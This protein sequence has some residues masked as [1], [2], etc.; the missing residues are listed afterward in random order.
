MP[1]EVPRP[2]FSL[3]TAVAAIAARAACGSVCRSASRGGEHTVGM[4]EDRYRA[5]VHAALGHQA[6]RGL[7]SVT[8][9][10]RIV[11]QQ[12]LSHARADA[13]TGRPVVASPQVRAGGCS[14]GILAEHLAGSVA[15]QRIPPPCSMLR[16]ASLAGGIL[17]EHLAGS[18]APQRIPPPCSMLRS[19][20]L[21]QV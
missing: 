15:P 20:S 18:V 17:A 10:A 1:I 2:P 14:G 21:A 8:S 6:A 13:T 11:G 5:R 12:G 16:S 4:S 3:T 19:A 7:Q 9:H